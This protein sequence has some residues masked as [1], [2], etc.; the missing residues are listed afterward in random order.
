MAESYDQEEPL[1]VRLGGLLTE[2]PPGISTL[3][4]LLQNADDA[5]AKSIV[6]FLFSFEVIFQTYVIDTTWHEKAKLVDRGLAENQG[7]ALLVHNDAVFTENDFASLKRL[8]DSMKIKDKMA[9]GKFGL[10]FNSV[11]PNE[12]LG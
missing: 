4:E 10:G 9:T 2:Y 8:G 7:P 6:I 11:F 1:T 5:G 12:M 3:K